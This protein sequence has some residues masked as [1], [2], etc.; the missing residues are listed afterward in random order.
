MSVVDRWLM[1]D[2]IEE[3]LPDEAHQIECIRGA[4][5]ELYDSWGYELVITPLI[6]YLDSLTVGVG[7]DLESHTFRLVDQSSGR[8][9]GVRPDITPQVARIDAHR[10]NRTGPAR[11]CYW[12][13]TLLTRP[14]ELGG[15]RS[16]IQVGAEL[17][18]HQGYQSD[19]EILRLMLDSLAI[20]GV[21][22]AYIDIGHVGVFKGLAKQAGLDTEAEAA[23]FDA[24]Q[25]KAKPEIEVL[26]STVTDKAMAAMLG[27]LADI[28]GDESALAQA[29]E[30][31]SAA[32]EDVHAALSDL[33]N[34]AKALRAQYPDMNM[35]F[36][37]AE[38]RG[39]GYHTG[40]VFAAYTPGFG[41]SVAQGGRYDDVGAVFGRARPATGFSL[42]LRNLL[43][44]S[45]QPSE[46]L[47]GIFAPVSDVA[48]LD[49][50]IIALREQGERVICEL[51]GQD[52][53]V[54][55]AG[56]DRVLVNTDGEW[57]VQ[58]V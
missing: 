48:G 57:Q 44:I 28:T 25:R 18:G 32:D 19:V 34:I 43:T 8:T 10:L 53:G 40:I 3:L 30:L 21:K 35:H 27:G 26:L 20:A 37:L 46:G 38:L 29:R 12:G 17:Y 13:P 7:G 24:L 22:D 42:D 45:G 49:E 58:S 56:C 47:G 55:E 5:F 23:L 14:R 54:A 31:L 36:D 51:P 52:G 2:G 41:Q 33:E 9:V 4:L 11:L 16:P 39:Y 15:S 6:E 1:P 50:A